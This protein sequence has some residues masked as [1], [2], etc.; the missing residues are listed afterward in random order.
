VGADVQDVYV[1]TSR[2][3]RY[4]EIVVGAQDR[5]IR[6]RSGRSR[7]WTMSPDGQQVVAVPP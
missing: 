4:P 6:C 3:Q 7:C 2:A 5:N 1:T